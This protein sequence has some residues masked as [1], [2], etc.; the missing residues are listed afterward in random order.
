MPFPS[1]APQQKNT[2]TCRNQ[3]PN[4]LILLLPPPL[5]FSGSTP[6]SQA[7]LSPCAAGLLL[8]WTC[9]QTLHTLLTQ[10]PHVAG[11]LPPIALGQSPSNVVP[12]TWQYACS[13]NRGQHQSKDTPAPERGKENYTH[14]SDC[15][16][17]GGVRADTI[18]TA[19]PPM[20]ESFSGDNTGK[21][22]CSSVLQHFAHAWSDSTQ[23]QD[24]P[25]LAH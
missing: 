5:Y 21:V 2:G 9:A 25:R 13:P 7:C 3:V 18:L 24:S 17:R 14:L 4:L 6:S 22:P 20:Y 16:P 8:Q 15:G 19:G 1:P 10:P 11:P 12:H 23:A